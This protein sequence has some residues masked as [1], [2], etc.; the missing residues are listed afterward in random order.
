M[1]PLSDTRAL[2][3]SLQRKRVLVTGG[4][5]GI[6]AGLV[7]AFVGAGRARPVLRYRGRRC[8]RPGGAADALRRHTRRSTGAV[9]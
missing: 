4:A 9:T 7:E 2:Y 1:M 5:S 3:P 6:G 8:R